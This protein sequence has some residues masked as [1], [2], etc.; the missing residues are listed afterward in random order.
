ML[1]A[2]AVHAFTALGVVCA[3]MAVMAI[4]DQAWERVFVWLGLALLI[5]GIDGT[6]AR[7]VDV[8]RRLPRISGDRLDQVVDYVTYVLVPVL[9]L[10][11]AGYLVGTWGL[12]LA[13]LILLSSLYH[14]ADL[15]N[16]SA[17]HSFVGFPAI[18]NL[19]AFYF[20]AFG[21]ERW[22]VAVV[23][24]VCVALTFVPM[25]WVHPLRVTRLRPVTLLLT[26]CW[27]I[28]GAWTLWYG[29]PAPPAAQ[30]LLAGV[31]LYGVAL[32]LLRPLA[33]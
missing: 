19:V 28:A 14:F 10:L 26:L 16:K 2:G 3:L 30:T 32:A 24:L 21:L 1:A 27:A 12:I 22:L 13:A 5:D 6:F 15:G 25:R 18:W 31:G 20:F 9:A 11:Q 4:L 17:D 8:T 33:R 23:V 7:Y 29:F